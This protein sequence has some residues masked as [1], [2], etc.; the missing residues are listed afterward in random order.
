MSEP[1]LAHA[2]IVKV[3]SR[4]KVPLAVAG[5]LSLPLFFAALM[6]M[7]LAVEKPTVHHLLKHGK[8]VVALGDPSGWNEAAVW[9][10]AVA[11]AAAVVLVGV[12][13]IF[14]RRA[15]VP[16]AALAAIGVALAILLPLDGWRDVHTGRYPDGVDL[17]PRSSTDD[18]YLRGE[19]EA[20][21]RLTA[22]QLGLVTIGMAGFAIAVFLALEL[23]RRRRGPAPAPPPPPPL[24]V[25]GLAR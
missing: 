11:T 22:L 12:G 2:A 16:L 10:L 8:P 24:A 19:W 1:A 18:I 20:A 13:G 5:I 7:S 6:A 15:G 25:E 14:A 9:L 4:S 23:R 17:I 21:A 3:R